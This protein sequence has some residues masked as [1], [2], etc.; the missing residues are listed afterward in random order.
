[1]LRLHQ[2]VEMNKEITVDSA[3]ENVKNAMLE[4]DRWIV[5]RINKI[6]PKER[7]PYISINASFDCA[8]LTVIALRKLLEVLEENN[9]EATW[10]K[11]REDGS[12]TLDVL[13]LKAH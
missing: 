7:K 9:F 13:F 6:N 1:M 8:G 12:I 11:G 10:I 3:L 4:F 5:L 2:I